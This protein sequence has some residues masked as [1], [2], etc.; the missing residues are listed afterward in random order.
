MAP[1]KKAQDRQSLS[2]AHSS[3]PPNSPSLSDSVTSQDTEQALNPHYLCS[4]QLLGNSA[5]QSSSTSL[6]LEHLEQLFLKL[7]EATSKSPDSAKAPEAVKPE[8]GDDKAE[9][10]RA[11]K[12]EF[13]TVNEMYVPNEI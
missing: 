4:C 12:L 5:T 6:T 1:K 13:K 2:K 8:D 9:P 3:T 10:A 11:S 7:I